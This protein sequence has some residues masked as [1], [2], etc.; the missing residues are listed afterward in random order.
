MAQAEVERDV[1]THPEVGIQGVVL[2]YE[3]NAALGGGERRDVLTVKGHGPVIRR[4]QAGDH[5][6]Q[7]GLAA[8]R[9]ANDAH[10]LTTPDPQAGLV[11][12]QVTP[13]P[14]R[15]IRLGDTYK[16]D[17]AA[18][19]HKGWAVHCCCSGPTPRTTLGSSTKNLKAV[20]V[21]VP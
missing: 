2:E 15:L 9:W 5:T 3:A 11:Q 10:R 8:A 19:R 12:G 20:Q 17:F 13:F 1:P 4:L 14:S 21:C 16:V 6:Q 18:R 7:G